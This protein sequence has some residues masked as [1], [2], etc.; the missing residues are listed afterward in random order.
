[1]SEGSKFHE[2]TLFRGCWGHVCVSHYTQFR[3]PFVCC[4]GESSSKRS[5]F[6][7]S[8]GIDSVNIHTTPYV[9]GHFHR[10]YW[11]ACSDVFLHLR[12]RW[13][14]KA[15]NIAFRVYI[16]TVC[17]QPGNSNCNFDAP[18]LIGRECFNVTSHNVCYQ[19]DLFCRTTEMLNLCQPKVGL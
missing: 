12:A 16:F 5:S 2:C 7:I 13:T 4:S 15:T 9:K 10:D 8:S 17:V 1:M 14:S 19:K 11:V 3:P 6:G 18:G